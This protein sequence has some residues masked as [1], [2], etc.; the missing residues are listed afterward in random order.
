MADPPHLPIFNPHYSK[1]N[2][3]FHLF[4]NLPKELRL[5]IW[6]HALRRHRIIKLHLTDPALEDPT[7]IRTKLVN[8]N[9]TEY[10]GSG[11]YVVTLDGRSTI[12]KLLH[13]CKDSREETLLHYRARIPC[14]F[15][16][17]SY[18][19][20]N[21][22]L[23]MAT[24]ENRLHSVLTHG[25][26]YFNPEWDFLSIAS[27]PSTSSFAPAFLH[28]LK[29]RYDPRGVGLLNLVVAM[30]DTESSGVLEIEPSRLSPTLRTSISQTLRNL[31][32][33]F[34]HETVTCGRTN[35]GIAWGG[36]SW[37]VWFNRSMPISTKV[38]AFDRIAPDPRPVSRDLE[39]QYM[40]SIG[41]EQYAR[42]TRCLTQFGVAPAE[43]SA[44]VKFMMSHRS[45][46]SDIQSREHAARWLEDDYKRGWVDRKGWP[47][48]AKEEMKDQ[49][50]VMDVEPAFGFWLFS[51]EAMDAKVSEGEE[52]L[53]DMR[54]YTPELGLAVIP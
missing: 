53:Y 48:K 34:L 54:M 16:R 4:S 37:K 24:V 17:D 19:S 39:K 8:I 27:W 23:V 35:L 46:V 9:A 18:P 7:T 43:T 28:D 38:L 2:P 26:F 14:R 49:D 44:Q 13:V 52:K 6:R 45:G 51:L 25:T 10:V 32:Q 41:R 1:T 42:Y 40:G 20:M 47:S 31:Q 36:F 22:C 33:V 3:S 30:N 11:R 12:S 29:T 21:T 15:V 5:L 50:Y